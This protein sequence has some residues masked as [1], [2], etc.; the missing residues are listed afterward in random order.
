[1]ECPINT[2]MHSF[3]YTIGVTTT[4]SICYYIWNNHY[5]VTASRLF[6]DAGWAYCGLEVRVTRLR[7]KLSDALSPLIALVAPGEIPEQEI[8]FYNADNEVVKSM[9]LLEFREL[10]ENWDFEYSYGVYS[11][12]NEE[13]HSM[14]RLFLTHVDANLDEIKFSSAS[15]LSAVLKEE[16]KDDLDLNVLSPGFR[17]SLVVGNELFTEEFMRHTFDM[18]LPEEYTIETIDSSVTQNVVK[19]NGVV[20]VRADNLE[21]VNPTDSRESSFEEVEPRKKNSFLFEWIGTE[22]EISSKKNV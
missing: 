20:R 11:I 4:A 8:K 21:F 16:G 14:T 5:P 7:Q 2:R 22:N 9:G 19:K 13:N 17:S 6:T 12:K 10:S 3:F 1:M 15:L 18:S